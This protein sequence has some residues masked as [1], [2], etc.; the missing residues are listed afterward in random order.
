MHLNEALVQQATEYEQVIKQLSQNLE[1]QTNNQN[2]ED[3]QT[4]LHE[5]R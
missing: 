2:D 3:Y 1:K 5:L 4:D